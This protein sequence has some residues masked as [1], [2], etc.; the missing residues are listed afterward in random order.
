MHLLNAR[1]RKLEYFIGSSIP[2]YA[3]LSHTWGEEEV[4]MQ[5]LINNR[6]VE[7]REGYGKIHFTCEQ[8]V[9]DGLDYVWVDTCCI[10]KTSSAEL[11]EAINS[12]YNCEQRN[13]ASRG[14]AYCLLGLFDVNMPLLYGEGSKAFTRLQEEIVRSSTDLSVFAWI[15]WSLG[16]PTLLASS[17]RDFEDA[18]GVKLNRFS[19]MQDPSYELGNSGLRISLPVIEADPLCTMNN[20]F[21]GLLN[22][23]KDG[24]FLALRLTMKDIRSTTISSDATNLMNIEDPRLTS[25]PV[26]AALTAKYC[27]VIIDRRAPERTAS[28]IVFKR[29]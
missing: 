25:V 19:T 10:D 22:C 9:V 7:R 26:E 14:M 1:T 20:H 17:P 2:R 29:V 11:S 27:N 4:S 15:D 16:A 23:H 18:H 12:M 3:I 8:A 13:D 28:S 24:K 5:D 21:F 6:N